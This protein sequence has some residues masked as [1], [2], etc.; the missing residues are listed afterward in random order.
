MAIYGAT[1]R[2]A[3]TVAIEA[4]LAA[5][6]REGD[7]AVEARGRL[8][9]VGSGYL[10][11]ALAEP[12]GFRTACG[13]GSV[14]DRGDHGLGSD[15]LLASALDDLVAARRQNSSPGPRSTASP[16]CRSTCR[17]AAWTM[18]KPLRSGSACST[19]SS[20]GFWR[21]VYRAE[22]FCRSRGMAGYCIAIRRC[23]SVRALTPR[24]VPPLLP[25]FW[26]IVQ[27]RHPRRP[28]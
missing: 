14:T 1:A 3:S 7:P 15:A 10:R 28:I 4:E 2:A 25:S 17:Y 11:F 23:V 22:G 19:W 27:L 18:P 8:H 16:C 9:A 21:P 12:G 24:R 20:A 6:S 26:Q 5:L 13:P